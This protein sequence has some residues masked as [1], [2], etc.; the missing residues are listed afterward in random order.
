MLPT[1]R[2]ERPPVSMTRPTHPGESVRRGPRRAAVALILAL[3]LVLTGGPPLPAQEQPSDPGGGS[4]AGDLDALRHT[5]EELV[6]DEAEL[7]VQYDQAGIRIADLLPR[8]QAAEVALARADR[9]VVEAEVDLSERRD[10]EAEATDSLAAART[11]EDDAE[12]R[13]RIYA[14]ETYMDEGDAAARG[15][16]FEVLEGDDGSLVRRGYR[17][18]VGDQQRELIEAL[19]DARSASDS[20]L[21]RA[22]ATAREAVRQRSRV[23]QL[24]TEAADALSEST[25][26][27]DDA[28]AER[29]RQDTLLREVRARKGSIGARITSLQKAADEVAALL[30]AAQGVEE[31]WTP[32]AVDV[33]I[34]LKGGVISSEFGMR[35]HPILDVTRLH[36][37]VDIGAP[38][39]APVLAAADGI[40]V[41]AEDR[42]GYG[43][44]VLLAHGS[45][46]STVYAHNSALSVQVGDVVEQGDEIAEAGSTGLSTG[47]HI[48]FETRLKG[49]P[50]NPRSFLLLDEDASWAKEDD[51]GDGMPNGRD[52]APDD[53]QVPV[54]R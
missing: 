16:I 52:A 32:E 46:L 38:Q 5:Y 34:P 26:L 13:L 11:E 47:P 23:G 49:A 10:D 18:T 28:V 12:E 41:A 33:R 24:R 36:A 9:A 45:T 8:V 40:V 6:G 42:G 53:P 54:P 44:T 51:D 17:R 1:V 37:G 19:V 39:G 4:G 50:A 30:A 15:S 3:V 48:H 22:R 25:R 29:E 43:L 20:A 27:A 7:L 31:E 21:R 14:V 2:G 35:S